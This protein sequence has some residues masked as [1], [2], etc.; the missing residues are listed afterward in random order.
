MNSSTTKQKLVIVLQGVYNS[1]KTTTLNLLIQL[2]QG[3]EA[4]SPLTKD[5]RVLIS[6]QG[7]TVYV[8]T[9]GDLEEVTEES[10]RHFQEKDY[11]ILV[12]A[13]RSRGKTHAPIKKYVLEHSVQVVWVEKRR[14]KERRDEVNRA[15]AQELK[16][17]IDAFIKAHP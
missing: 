7:K 5:R 15:Q 13:A 3:V 9:P 10:V 6:Y 14:V 17:R 16:D 11:D 1:G 4:P 12:T 8:A 2:L